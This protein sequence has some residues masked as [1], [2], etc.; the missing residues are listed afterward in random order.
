MLET[1]CPKCRTRYQLG[2]DHVC[3]KKAAS[4]AAST[5]TPPAAARALEVSAPRTGGRGNGDHAQKDAATKTAKAKK[6]PDAKAVLSGGSSA[7]TRGRRTGSAA[8]GGQAS[9]SRPPVPNS[10]LADALDRI[11]APDFAEARGPSPDRV[12]EPS[13]ITATSAILTQAEAQAAHL[14]PKKDT[15][16]GDRHAPGYWADYSKRRRE[17]ARLKAEREGK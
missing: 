5:S 17:A 13:D 4:A 12:R 14:A 3:P 6:K 8:G 15:R 1:I 10:R 2:T 16:K 9:R 7:P 11:A